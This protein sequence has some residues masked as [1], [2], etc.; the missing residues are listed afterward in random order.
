MRF[1]Q[2]ESL[3]VLPS[4]PR[5]LGLAVYLAHAR[6]P[7]VAGQKSYQR[8]RRRP[9]Q[10]LW[11]DGLT[12]AG[13][14]PAGCSWVDV[15]DCGSDCYE[16]MSTARR[17][18]HHFLFRVWHN[19]PV[20]VSAD[21]RRHESLFAY[22]RSLPVVGSETVALPQREREPGRMAKVCL[23]ARPVWIAGPHE[24]SRRRSA[25]E[26]EAWVL[27]VWEPSP[28]AG[29]ERPLEWVLLC[30]VPPHNM[31]ELQERC[32]WYACR[33]MLEALHD[34]QKRA[35][36]VENW[37]RL[38]PEPMAASLQ[39]CSLVALRVLQL[40]SALSGQAD[41]P[42]TQAA[43][44]TEIQLVRHATHHE[45]KRLTARDF[46]YAVAQLGGFCAR[47]P[48]DEPSVTALWRGC[49]RLQDMLQGVEL[50]ESLKTG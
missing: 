31:T 21:H 46:V 36:R 18:G 17:L 35:R 26:V 13:P 25:A 2:H 30:S 19:R 22:A 34:I 15:G 5:Q 10:E 1:L 33:W 4:P 16:A 12:A 3:A 50:H 6:Q 42:A 14:A 48:N 38:P 9:P 20:F 11:L 43:T 8:K 28:P 23:A 37:R 39:E 29:I 7:D 45:G 49:L 47:Q 24:V 40:R 41:E 27:H 44:E 32:A